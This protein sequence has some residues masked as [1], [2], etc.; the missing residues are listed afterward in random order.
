MVSKKLSKTAPSIAEQENSTRFV[1]QTKIEKIP[2]GWKILSIE[3]I[4]TFSNGHGFT[5][6]DWSTSG[7]PIIRIQNLNGSRNFNYYAGEPEKKWIVNPGELL[8]AWA[9]VKGVSFGPCLWSGSV[10]LLNQHIYRIRENSGIDK[11]WLFWALQQV[12]RK[13]EEHAHGF[14]YNLLHVRKAD[15]VNQLVLVPPLHEQKQIVDILSSV[16]EAIASTQAVIDQTRKVKQGLLQQLLTRGI[17]HTKFKESAIGEIPE[18]WEV[19]ELGDITRESAFGPRFSGDL[20][21]VDG[22]YGSV[23]TT[24]INENWEINYE[25]VPRA[26]L[27]EVQ[28]ENH[29]LI[30]GD[31]L[32]TRSGSCGIVCVFREQTIPMIPGAFLIRFRLKNYVNPEFV[33]LAMMTPT[34]Q[35]SMATMAAGGVQKNLSGTNLKKLLL[36]FPSLEEQDKI[37][38]HYNH[39]L[40]FHPVI[41]T[42]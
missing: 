14:K 27:P 9:G 33:R 36:P 11:H 34:A 39:V 42:G 26:M 5:P 31:L 21:D 40:Q 15:I 35:S 16:D 6:E 20:Y 41:S 30:D 32:V 2:E 19:V 24:D 25:T 4:C 23:R 17:G 12:T 37:V 13:I 1:E 8:F 18:S 3:E 7:L 28:C 22:N 29:R 10:G 38:S